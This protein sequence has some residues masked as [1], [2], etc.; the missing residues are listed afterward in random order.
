VDVLNAQRNLI[1][2]QTNYS[3]SRY[4]YINNQVQLRLAA[5]DLTRESIVQINQHLLVDA[6]VG[7]TARSPTPVAPPP[8]APAAPAPAAPPPPPAN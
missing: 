3:Q 7:S 5:G 8:A 1:Q 2:A 4:A 6:P